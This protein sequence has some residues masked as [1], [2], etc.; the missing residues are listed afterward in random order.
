[1]PDVLQRYN[2]LLHL[3]QPPEVFWKKK[4]LTSCFSKNQISFNLSNDMLKMPFKEWF[5]I[6]DETTSRARHLSSY[7]LLPVSWNQLEQS[8]FLS[9]NAT[10]VFNNQLMAAEGIIILVVLL[11]IICFM[12]CN[13]H[14]V[15]NRKCLKCQTLIHYDG[16]EHC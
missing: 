5:N 7:S 12:L 1:M 10:I 4:M 15:F 8:F 11:E 2:Q 9:H 13:I 3:L 14:A 6:T 16:Q